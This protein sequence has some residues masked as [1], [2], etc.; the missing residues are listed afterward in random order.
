[1]L[2]IRKYFQTARKF[3]RY[4]NVESIRPKIE[5]AKMGSCDISNYTEC[6]HKFDKFPIFWFFPMKLFFKTSYYTYN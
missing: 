3:N 5:T 6:L 4:F 1:M 2:T